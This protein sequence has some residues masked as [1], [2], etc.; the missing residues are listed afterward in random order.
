MIATVDMNML[1]SC[2]LEASG[3]GVSVSFVEM[4]ESD[5]VAAS[6]ET[7]GIRVIRD[8]IFI[9]EIQGANK[10]RRLDIEHKTSAYSQK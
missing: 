1:L 2:L 7:D 5:R 6:D 8:R 9:Y 10:V 4:T 3:D